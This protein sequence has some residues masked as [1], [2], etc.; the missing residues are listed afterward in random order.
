MVP[1]LLR[2]GV[3]SVFAARLLPNDGFRRRRQVLKT[4]RDLAECGFTWGSLSCS[5]HCGPRR[6]LLWRWFHPPNPPGA[7]PNPLG[8]HL[9]P[10][11]QV[12]LIHPY[13]R[14]VLPVRN[15]KGP[16]HHY[17]PYSR[18]TTY[19][20]RVTENTRHVVICLHLIDYYS[21]KE[22][23]PG[24]AAEGFPAVGGD[25]GSVSA[26]EE[27]PTKNPVQLGKSAG[28]HLM[29]VSPYYY[30]SYDLRFIRS[31]T[32]L[33]SQLDEMGTSVRPVW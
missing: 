6:I 10:Q 11:L 23:G 4:D 33:Q 24:A 15:F 19:F 7:Y 1:D 8:D 14:T 9:T 17:H 2:Q 21:G 31:G 18:H 20:Q 27:K 28:L 13:P 22:T 32:E 12:A 29:N 3:H 16:F 5:P 26:A 25:E 30:I